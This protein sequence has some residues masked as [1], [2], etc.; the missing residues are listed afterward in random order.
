MLPDW[1]RTLVP[2]FLIAQGLMVYLV[3]GRENLP[4]P[5]ILSRF[6]AE[7][8]QWSQ[9]RED[10]LE[11]ELVNELHADQLL[12]RIYVNRPTGALASLFLAWFQSQRGGNSQPH[13]PRICLP[14]SGWVPEASGEMDI[15]TAA[16]PIRVNRYLVVNRNERAV[17]LYWYQTPQR[18]IAGEWASKFWVLA[19]ALRRNR[20]DTALVRIVVWS[21]AGGDRAATETARNF[22]QGLYPLLRE[23]LP[24]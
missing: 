24:R 13:S 20:T 12:N 11:P 22:A 23:Q 5:P 19:D 9:L 14:A 3:S 18:A 2:V 10:P 21:A 4:A 15:E 16:G 8:S 1:P 6:P 7:I 17:V